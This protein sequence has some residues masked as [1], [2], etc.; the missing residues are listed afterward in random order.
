M[1]D[2]LTRT[3]NKR[4]PRNTAHTH[5]YCSEPRYSKSRH[6]T[7]RRRLIAA[8]YAS[9]HY[10]TVSNT[11]VDR[12]AQPVISASIH[13]TAVAAIHRQLLSLIRRHSNRCSGKGYYLRCLH[14]STIPTTLTTDLQHKDDERSTVY[15]HSATIKTYRHSCFIPK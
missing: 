3:I 1:C 15:E 14:K 8:C 11:W 5:C 10:T 4:E 6:K 13:M 2:N 12:A 7:P 9:Q